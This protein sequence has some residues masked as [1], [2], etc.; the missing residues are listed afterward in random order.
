MFSDHG[1]RYSELRKTMRGLLHERKPFFSIYLPMLFKSRYKTEFSN[2]QANS[3]KLVTPLDIHA[4]LKNLISLE[5]NIKEIEESK[6]EISLF[7]KISSNRNCQQ[8]GI[9]PHWCACLKRTEQKIDLTFIKIGMIFVDYLNDVIL[10]NQ[11]NL[12]H[13]LKLY[14]INKVYLLDTFIYPD[15]QVSK[16]RSLVQM[17]NSWW[18]RQEPPIETDY[19]KY[20]FQIVT[21]P[22]LAIFEFT[23]IF[24]ANY[25][26]DRNFNHNKLKEIKIDEATIS[27][28]NS[29]GN[30]SHCITN[31]LPNLR[32]YCYC[33]S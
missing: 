9:K 28:V 31:T 25:L 11:S 33:K 6:R 14:E 29:Y 12:C 8:A 2:L 7:K 17:I 24:E 13:T 1:P 20:L 26:Q 18:Y 30:S 27:R 21:Q 19:T 22:N 16:S 15:K 23:V 5:S 10:K 3:L 32:K 4:T